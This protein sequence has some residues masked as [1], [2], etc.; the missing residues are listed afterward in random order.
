VRRPTEKKTRPGVRRPTDFSLRRRKNKVE[1]RLEPWP[2]EYTSVLPTTRAS[3]VLVH[4][5]ESNSRRQKH[6]CLPLAAVH[7]CAGLQQTMHRAMQT[8]FVRERRCKIALSLSSKARPRASF[9]LFILY[10]GPRR[11]QARWRSRRGRRRIVLLLRARVAKEGDGGQPISNGEE[12]GVVCNLLLLGRI[13]L[14]RGDSIR[15]SSGGISAAVASRQL[16]ARRGVAP[17]S[18]PFLLPCGQLR[19][20][21]STTSTLQ[22]RLLSP[23]PQGRPLGRAGWATEQGPQKIRAPRFTKFTY[24]I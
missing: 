14:P 2:V 15:D 3:L 19:R 17:A 11:D 6:I 1:V 5:A 9:L 18:P 10:A 8:S 13:R 20:R 16:L 7:A 12:T 24:Y 21:V 23:S 4:K 22:L